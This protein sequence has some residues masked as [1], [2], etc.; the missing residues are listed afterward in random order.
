MMDSPPQLSPPPELKSSLDPSELEVEH[1]VLI[2]L[3]KMASVD[4]GP[5]SR[6]TARTE[7][8]RFQQNIVVLSM[9]AWLAEL[10]ESQPQVLK[11]APVCS[12]SG[13]V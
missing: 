11:W 9:L 5:G 1:L 3:Q 8:T 13:V 2:T 10:A 4:L 6:A 12:E 7:D